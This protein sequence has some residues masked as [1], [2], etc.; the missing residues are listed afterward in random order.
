MKPA[1]EQCEGCTLFTTHIN[2]MSYLH[3]RDV[4]YATLC[5]GPYEESSQYRKFI[6]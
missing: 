5:E 1:A 4:S 3:S 2:E 6:G